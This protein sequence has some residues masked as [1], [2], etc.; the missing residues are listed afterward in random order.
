MKE[1][2][3]LWRKRLTAMALSVLMLTSVF[4]PQQSSAEITSGTDQVQEMKQ[5]DQQK[6]EA[7]VEAQQTE[8]KKGEDQQTQETKPEAQQTEGANAGDQP[9]GNVTAE[10]VQTQ[11]TDPAAPQAQDAKLEIK[12]E[13]YKSGEG[14]T[15]VP[16][17]S[18]IPLEEE[19]RTEL[20]VNII[21]PTTDDP[22]YDVL[23][24]KYREL[25]ETRIPFKVGE[26]YLETDPIENNPTLQVLRAFGAGEKYGYNWNRRIVIIA[27]N[28][29]QEKITV[30]VPG[31]E[32]KEFTFVVSEKPAAPKDPKESK[33]Y[34]NFYLLN[35]QGE[36]ERKIEDPSKKGLTIYQ[37]YRE[38]YVIEAELKDSAK[39]DLKNGKD[40]LRATLVKELRNKV[41]KELGG[42]AEGEEFDR[43]MAE[44]LKDIEANI[45]T[46]L[47]QELKKGTWTWGVDS[48]GVT[49]RQ[50]IIKRITWDFEKREI[51]KLPMRPISSNLL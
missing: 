39:E 9:A 8:E 15:E 41:K 25:R 20:N 24:K 29:G 48:D 42:K 19:G 51:I 32:P 14:L 6:Q 36:R 23:I 34:F 26:Q 50:P 27:K 33:E 4:M 5:E 38:E 40:G 1:T 47:E 43:K 22:N 31:Y 46:I 3:R 49:E 7:Q 16:Q 2:S 21:E 18:I 35:E 11:G 30:E 17:D 45:D 37:P 44:G 10:N 12:F 13:Y 28:A